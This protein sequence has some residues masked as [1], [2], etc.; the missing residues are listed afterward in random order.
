MET[1]AEKVELAKCFDA[2]ARGI[3]TP[4]PVTSVI[5]PGDT[6]PHGVVVKRACSEGGAAVWG[7]GIEGIP[8]WPGWEA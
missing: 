7:T 5:R 2:I 4:R 8:E 6:I 1:F 3:G